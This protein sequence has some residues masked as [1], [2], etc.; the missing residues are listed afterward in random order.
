MTAGSKPVVHRMTPLERRAALSLSSIYSIRML[1]LFMLFPVISLYQDKLAEA[2]PALIGLAI[3]IY[4][5]T[6]GLLQIPFGLLSDR[7]GRKPVIYM[8]LLLFAL[9]SVV[10]A[11]S[12]SIYGV[13]AGR[14]LQGCGAIA[15]AIM[16][17]TADLTRE[18][19]RTKAMALI[20]MSIGTAFALALVLGP[21]FDH[22]VGLSGLFWFTAVMALLGMLVLKVMVPNAVSQRLHRDAEPVPAQFGQILRD[23]QLLRLDVGIFTLHMIL[24]ASFVVFP[25]VLQDV[26]GLDSARHWWVY[27]P[28]LLLSVMAMVPFIIMAE[29]HRR[30]KK[31]FLGAVLFVGLAQLGLALWYDQFWPALFMLLLFFTAFN[32]LEAS[33]PSLVSKMAPPASKGTA[34]GFYSSSQFLGAF[35]GGSLGGVLQGQFGYSSVFILGAAMALAWLLLA[36]SMKDP[37]Y[38]SSYLLN[39]GEIPSTQASHLSAQLTAISG[40]AEAIVIVEDQV[41]YLKVDSKALDEEQLLQYSVSGPDT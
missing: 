40:V 37:R 30:M 5:L 7:I 12:D 29:R 35:L 41:A 9:G 4:G 16:A 2:T 28:V 19:H 11:M 38:L 24:T 33:L 17:L 32:L 25:L 8:G 36:S 34:M 22:W 15:A 23:T 26:L 27:L 31:V 1:G 14:A 18:E 21:L 20:G 6:Q 13:I 3:G 39:I 10:A